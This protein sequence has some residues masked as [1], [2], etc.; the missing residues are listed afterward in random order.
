M[1]RSSKLPVQEP[2]AGRA[3]DARL[4]RARLTLQI[5]RIRTHMFGAGWRTLREIKTALEEIHAPAVFPESSIS[6]QLRNLK[7]Q[8][9]FLQLL[10]RRRAGV[11]GS[12]SGIWEYKLL[13]PA[14][15]ELPVKKQESAPVAI[16]RVDTVS[17][18]SEVHES[19]DPKE[20]EQFLRETRRAVF[21]EST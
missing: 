12:G 3:Y 10:R 16:S 17:E 11:R 15:L 13:P 2:F 9:Y 18:H 4:D 8:P 6:A 5:E 19:G 20:L 21:P 14:Q 7:K 1:R